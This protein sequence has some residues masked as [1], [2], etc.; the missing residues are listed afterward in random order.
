MLE[1][2]ASTPE[3]QEMELDIINSNP[4]YNLVSKDKEQLTL[5]DVAEEIREVLQMGAE[6]YLLRDGEMY[7]GIIDFLMENPRDEYPWL[8][9]LIIRKDLQGRGYGTRALEMYFQMMKERQVTAVRLGVL[10]HNEPGHRYW[11][12]QGFIAVD[13]VEMADGK[14]VV[15]YERRLV[16]LPE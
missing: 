15:V 11:T 6:R 12:G 7:I 10:L 16:D 8:G 1:F 2:V 3:L 9:F 13:R 4:Y 5:T 14:M